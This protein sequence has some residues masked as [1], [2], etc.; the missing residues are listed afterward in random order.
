MRCACA[1]KTSGI[2]TAGVPARSAP[3]GCPLPKQGMFTAIQHIDRRQ[4]LRRLPGERRQYPFEAL[5]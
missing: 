3:R 2:D 1:A 5:D 4:S